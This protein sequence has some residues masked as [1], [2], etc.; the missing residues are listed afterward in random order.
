MMLNLTTFTSSGFR[1]YKEHLKLSILLQSVAGPISLVNMKE[2]TQSTIMKSN[3]FRQSS[4]T[5]TYLR[6]M[7]S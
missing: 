6:K 4:D 5:L 3:E 2:N 7:R 1:R